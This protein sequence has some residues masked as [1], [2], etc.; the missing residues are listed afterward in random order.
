M[1]MS[2]GAQ[3]DAFLDDLRALVDQRV[4]QRWTI[5]SSLILRGV[6]PSSLR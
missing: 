6:M 1:S 3:R 5:S 2:R 4:D